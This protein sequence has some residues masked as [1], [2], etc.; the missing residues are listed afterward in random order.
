M[1]SSPYTTKVGYTFGNRFFRFFCFL[2][3]LLTHLTRNIKEK[4]H[5]RQS[6]LQLSLLPDKDH[7]LKRSAC[8]YF[9]HTLSRLVDGL[10]AHGVLLKDKSANGKMRRAGGNSLSQVRLRVARDRCI[11]YLAPSPVVPRGG[12][13]FL[14]APW[15]GINCYVCNPIGIPRA[16]A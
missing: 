16:V 6:I 9:V 14:R 11:Y 7:Q 1:Q 10:S 15:L 13:A 5:R 3:P 12:F 2:L 8:N 4:K